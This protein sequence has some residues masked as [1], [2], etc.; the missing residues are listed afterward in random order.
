MGALRVGARELRHNLRE[1]IDRAYA[2]EAFDVTDH[3][4]PVCRLVPPEGRMS[5]LDR[6]IADGHVT[7]ATRLFSDIPPPLDLGPGLMTMEEALEEDRE[8]LD[9]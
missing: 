2:G 6:L 9:L 3:G 4:R 5:A 1:Y 8:E 7:R